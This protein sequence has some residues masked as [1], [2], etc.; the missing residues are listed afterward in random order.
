MSRFFRRKKFCRFTSEGVKE[1][2]YK[3]I[4][5]LR[6][7]VSETGKIVPSRVTGTKARYQRQLSR[8]IKRARFLAL[9]PYSDAH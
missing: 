8:A 7:Y 1:I 5:M 3:D 9:L 2:D 4:A 6:N